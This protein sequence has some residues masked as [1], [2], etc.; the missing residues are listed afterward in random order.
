M[1][2]EQQMQGR[3][4]TD[5]AGLGSAH[6]RMSPE[7]AAQLARDHYGI[8]GTTIRFETEKDDTFRLTTNDG[9]ETV[10]K[11]A[12]PGESQA[13]IDLQITLLEHLITQEIAPPVPRIIRSNNDE[14][15]FIHQDSAGQYRH[16]RMLS[17]LKGIPLSD[18]TSTAEEREKVGEALAKLRLAM[19]GFSHPAENHQLAWDVQHLLKLEYL[20]GHVEDTEHRSML[21]RG[22][23]R[24][25]LLEP[26]LQACRYQVLHNDFSRSNIVVDHNALDFVTGIIDFGDAVRTAIVID[27][28]TALLN[29]LPRE[30]QEDMFRDARDVLNGYL[31][32]ADLTDSEVVLLPHLV[33][34]RVI[35]RA[36]LTTWRANKF[37]ENRTYI[38]RN[39]G[40][41]WAQ[42]A[43]FLNQ[44]IN[45][46]SDQITNR[47]NA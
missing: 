2:Q 13:E 24:F 10:L 22:L 23:E 20:L 37:P 17:Y 40:Q 9:G 46:V 44:S 45:Q 19:S 16:V 42:I 32:F 5:A 38:M 39:T 29:Q 31:R 25:A 36:L 14:A 12:N 47:V 1:S 6:I 18:T 3:P 35:A 27:V 34:A 33:M 43:W 41:G 8:K 4:I 30:P 26:Q 7:E 15:S 11:I 21:K 28:S